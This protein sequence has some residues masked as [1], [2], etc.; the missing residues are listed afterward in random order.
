MMKAFRSKFLSIVCYYLVLFSNLQPLLTEEIS[1]A[2]EKENSD[3]KIVFPIDNTKYYRIFGGES[4]E[5]VDTENSNSVIDIQLPEN[6]AS[7][8]YDYNIL[9]NDGP[10]SY[11]YNINACSSSTP[12][13]TDADAMDDYFELKQDLDPLSPVDAIGDYDCD[14]INN[15]TEYINKTDIYNSDTDNDSLSD[16]EEIVEYQTNP[17]NHDTDNDGLMDADEVG[18][19]L[20]MIA[21]DD[22][23]LGAHSGTTDGQKCP[24]I[25]TNGENYLVIW[26]EEFEHPNYV[27]RG[28]FFTMNGS[29]IGM[30][31][32]V[33]S[34]T[35]LEHMKADITSNGEDYFVVW[36]T[37]INDQYDVRGLI[38]FENGTISDVFEINQ[39]VADNQVSPSVA[40]NGSD[41]FVVWQS[42][43]GVF[44]E[45]SEIVGRI[46]SDTGAPLCDDIHINETT[47]L[48]QSYPDVSSNAMNYLV[49]W[50]SSESGTGEVDIKGQF[51]DNIGNKINSEFLVNNNSINY[52]SINHQE[53]PAVA[54]NGIDYCVTWISSHQDNSSY[55]IS[56]RLIL[57]TTPDMSDEIQVN[58]FTQYNQ[59]C[60]SI[61]TWKSNYLITW[62]SNTQDGDGY[63]VYGQ[64]ISDQGEAIGLEFRINN[65]VIRDQWESE[66]ASA[67]NS[68][69]V[70]WESNEIIPTQYR[71]CGDFYKL[72][73][74]SDPLHPDSDGDGLFDSDEISIGTDPYNSDTDSDG[75]PDGW[76]VNYCFNPL[77]QSDSSFDSDNDGLGNDEEYDSGTNPLVSDTDKDTLGD[78]VEIHIY[79]TNP[80]SQDTDHDGMPDYEEL[81]YVTYSIGSE[82][83]VNAYTSNDQN[84]PSLSSNKD[85]YLISWTSV[86][87]DAS[88][89]GIAGRIID[90]DGHFI[91][92]DN[93]LTQYTN[94]SQLYPKSAS[95]DANYLLVWTGSGTLDGGGIYGRIINTTGNPAGNDFLI[96]TFTANTQGNPDIASNGLNYLVVWHSYNLPGDTST[97]VCARL[98]DEQGTFISDEIKMNT[99]TE[100]NQYYPSVA[101]NKY[102]YLVVWESEQQ[103]SSGF[104]IYGQFINTQ[105]QK[106]G[107]EFKINSSY[108]GNQQASSIA[109][110]GNK[111]LVTWESDSDG[112]G[113]GIYGQLIDNDGNFITQEFRINTYT[114]GDQSNPSIASNGT[115]YL[116]T[117]E[118]QNQDGNGKGIYGQFIDNDGNFIDSEFHINNYISG[119]KKNPAVASR[120]KD[121]VI[122]WGSN[123]QDGNGYGIYGACISFSIALDPT[124]PDTDSDGLPDGWE[125]NN[126]LN[127]FDPNDASLDFDCDGLNTAVEFI[128]NTDYRNPDTDGDGILD[129]IEFQNG[130]DPTDQYSPNSPVLLTVNPL[131]D[132]ISDSQLVAISGQAVKNG[133]L[134]VDISSIEYRID[135]VAEWQ[136]AQIISKQYDTTPAV[137]PL[138][139]LN[140]ITAS[141]NITTVP[142][143]LHSDHIIHLRALDQDNDASETVLY[144]FTIMCTDSDNDGISDSF[145]N[146]HRT[147]PYKIDTDNDGL[148]DGLEMFNYYSDPLKMDTDNDSLQDGDEV[149]TYHTSPILYDTDNDGLSDSEEIIRFSQQIQMNSALSNARFL[150]VASSGENYLIAWTDLW[151]IYGRIISDSG[152]FITQE[153]QINSHT[154]EKQTWPS[155]ASDGNNFCVVWESDKENNGYGIRGQ[156]IS[157]DGVLLN[158]EINI[159]PNS[160]DKELSPYICSNGSNY[161]LT[162][163][164]RLQGKIY[165]LILDN[166]GIPQGSIKLVST[167]YNGLEH[168]PIT[169]DG[170]N[171]LTTWFNMYSIAAQFIDIDGEFVGTNFNVFTD[172]GCNY[173]PSVASDKTNYFITWH[174]LNSS[175]WGQ[176]CDN[177][178]KLLGTRFEVAS[179]A[180]DSF[181]VSNGTTYLFAWDDGI[182]IYAQLYNSNGAKIEDQFI[183]A[184]AGGYPKATA[185][186]DGKDYL[187][188][189][190]NGNYVF[191]KFLRGYG[192]NPLI[193]DCDNDGIKDGDE[194]NNFHTD[195]FNPDYDNDGISDGNEVYEY[196]TN[197]KRADTDND[198]MPDSWEIKYDLTPLTSSDASSDLDNDGLSNLNEFLSG[199]YPNVIDSDNDGLNDNEFNVY[200][201]SPL[202]SDSDNDGMSDGWEVLNSLNPINPNDALLDADNDSIT[203]VQEYQ[204]GINPQQSNVTGSI[205]GEFVVDAS[206]S[207]N[208][209]VP[210]VVPPGTA[211]MD[212][213]LSLNYST[214]A[215]NSVMGIGWS[216]SG[217]SM[218]TRAPA[219]LVQDGFVDGVD[220]DSNDRFALDGQRLFTIN[221]GTYGA[222][223]TEYRTENESFTKVVSYG[224]SGNGPSYFKAW[225]KAGLIMEYGLS[226]DSKIKVNF[227]N[228]PDNDT[229]LMWLVTRIIDTKGN[230]I[231]FNYNKTDEGEFYLTQIDY[232][233]NTNTGLVPYNSIKFEYETRPDIRIAYQSGSKSKSSL[234]LT[235]IKCY[236]ESNIVRSYKFDYKPQLDDT[237]VKYSR[238]IGI[239]QY[240]SD[241]KAL[242]KTVF[243]WKDGDLSFTQKTPYQ[244]TAGWGFGVLQAEL[245]GD[246]KTD[247]LSWGTV[248]DGL[249]LAFVPFL[250]VGDGAFSYNDSWFYNTGDGYRNVTNPDPNST[251][252]PFNLIPIDIN[253]DGLTDFVHMRT[254]DATHKMLLVPHVSNGNCGFVKKN[255]YNTGD[256][257]AYRS[258]NGVEPYDLLQADINADGLMDFVHVMT[259]A[260]SNLVFIMHKSNGDGTFSKLGTYHTNVP[261]TR[262]DI[263]GAS[264]NVFSADI[265]SDGLIDLIHMYPDN[266]SKLVIR[267]YLSDGKG[268]FTQGTVFYTGDTY[269][270]VTQGQGPFNVTP[271]D[272]N[273]DGNMDFIHMLIATNGIMTFVPYLSVGNG[274]FKRVNEFLTNE[275]YNQIPNGHSEF[276]FF[277]A[278]INGDGL[279]DVVHAKRF[280]NSDNKISLTFYT[281]KGDGSFIKQPNFYMDDQYSNHEV[282]P[283]NILQGDINGDGLTDLI[284]LRVNSSYKL[285]FKPYILSGN[286][287]KNIT[288]IK[289]GMEVETTI[290]YKPLTDN[291]VYT[292]ENTS[293]YPKT[294]NPENPVMDIQPP[295]YVVSSYSTSDGLGG[296]YTRSYLYG[297]SKMS[298]KRGMLGFHWM[299]VLDSQTNIQNYSE[300]LQDYPYT[301]MPSK[302][303]VT[304][305]TGNKTLSTSENT[306]ES[307]DYDGGK[308]HFVYSKKSDEKSYELNG[309][310]TTHVTTENVYD[311]YGNAT[312]IIVD[313]NDGHKKTTINNYLN[314]VSKWFLGRLIRAEVTSEAPGQDPKT[315]VSSFAYDT[316]TGLLTYEIVEPQTDI[317][318]V[319]K[320]DYDDYGNKTKVTTGGNSLTPTDPVSSTSFKILP[321]NITVS[322]NEKIQ[323]NLLPNTDSDKYFISGAKWSVEGGGSID[324]ATGVFI[325]GQT[326]GGPFTVTAEYN[327][328]KVKTKLR[329]ISQSNPLITIKTNKAFNS[330]SL[331]SNGSQSALVWDASSNVYAQIFNSS[332]SASTGEISIDPNHSQEYHPVVASL[333]SNF[334]VIWENNGLDGD[335]LGVF[336]TLLS[337]DGN[338]SNTSRIN[339]SWSGTQK[340]PAIASSSDN[341]F[342]AWTN[343]NDNSGYGISARIYN[344]NAGQASSEYNVNNYTTGDQ[345]RPSIASDGSYYLNIWDGS[346]AQGDGIY[347]QLMAKNG[348]FPYGDINFNIF[349]NESNHFST[350]VSIASAKNNSKYLAVWEYGEGSDSTQ[351]LKYNSEI[352]GRI[353]SNTTSFPS[354]SAFKI[355]T[356]TDNYKYQPQVVSE[357]TDFF[358]VWASINAYSSTASV[359]AAYIPSTVTAS[360]ASTAM[361]VFKL[362]EYSVAEWIDD[363]INGGPKIVR[364]GDYYYACWKTKRSTDNNFD[365]VGVKI[366]ASNQGD[367]D[368]DG[369]TNN[370][371]YLLGTNPCLADTDSDGLSD[372]QEVNTY[373]TNPLNPDT[374]FDGY[375]DNTDPDPLDP[376]NPDEQNT[377][378]PPP[379]YEPNTEEARIT[380]SVYDSR[381]RFAIQTTNALGHTQTSVYDPKLGVPISTTGPNGLTTTWE[382]DG[383]G[384]KI[385]ETQADNTST[386]WIN[387]S[388]TG[389]S[390]YPQY[391]SYFA[392]TKSTGS[393]PSV[394]YYDK[395]GRELR[396]Q[397]IGFN[398]N[399]ILKDKQ[400]NNLGQLTQESRNYFDGNTVYWT[401]YQYDLIGRAV[402]VTTPD[403]KFTT[404]AYNGLST[405]IT[406]ALNQTVTHTNNSQGKL[407]KVVDGLG[408][409]TR[410]VYDPLDNLTQS[411]DND[412]NTVTIYYD[413][414]GQKTSMDDP[415]MGHWEY[416][417]NVFGELV[418]QKDA[419]GQITTLE[420]DKLG[421]IVRRGEPDGLSTGEA[422]WEYDNDY[423]AVGKLIRINGVNGFIKELEYDSLGR[424]SEVKTTFDNTTYT[425]G[426]TYDALSRVDKTIY[427]TGF[428]IKNIY[429]NLGFLKQVINPTSNKLYWQAD[430]VD[431]EGKITY[432]TLGNGIMTLSGYDPATGYLQSIYSGRGPSDAVQNLGYSFDALGNLTSRTDKNQNLEELFTYDNLNR[433]VSSNFVG[434]EIKTYQYDAIGNIT[435]KSD[436]GNY[437]YGENGAGPHAVTSTSGVLNNTYTY[438][439]NGNM[440]KNAGKT[441]TYNSFNK[442]ETITKDN[443][444]AN[445]TTTFIYDPDRA[446]YK[447]TAKVNGKDILTYYLGIFEK[448]ITD[449]TIVSNK[450]YISAGTGLVAIY[451]SET[452]LETNATKNDTCFFHKDHLGSID[453]ITNELGQVLERFSYDPHGKRRNTDWTPALNELALKGNITNRGFTGHEHI[454]SMD[455]IHMNGRVYDPILGR[456]LSPD[457]HIESMGNPQTLNRYTYVRNNPLSYTDPSGYFSWKKFWNQI[458]KPLLSLAIAIYLPVFLNLA[459]TY[460]GCFIGGFASGLVSSDGNLKS[461]LISGFTG[462]A[463]HGVAKFANK[464]EANYLDKLADS[465]GLDSAKQL[466]EEVVKK[467]HLIKDIAKTLPHGL[468]GGISNKLQGGKFKDGFL[469]SASAQLFSPFVGDIGG[470]NLSGR[471]E[472]TVISAVIG[473]TTSV[474]GGG[475]FANGAMMGAFKNLYNAETTRDVSKRSQGISISGGSIF[476]ITIDIGFVTDETG[477]TGIYLGGSVGFGVLGGSVCYKDSYSNGEVQTASSVSI[478][479]DLEGGFG[480]YGGAGGGGGTNGGYA[481]RKIG[482]GI[483]AGLQGNLGVNTEI[484]IGN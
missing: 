270:E 399:T 419:K 383:F 448:V 5:E 88:S 86:G 297:G 401:T 300:Y 231:K 6:V 358:V 153:F 31:F 20:S 391:A 166:E 87:Q 9:D 393:V 211:G 349:V 61:T 97:G 145:E 51:F 326:V 224:S 360:T 157:K 206:G 266:N 47:L 278:D 237:K 19:T 292:R 67:P 8:W 372:G 245:N 32:S 291:S 229:V 190:E 48:N 480:A 330:F 392:Y 189:W 135:S 322:V 299:K 384:R 470:S 466:S 120:Q 422:T 321:A 451:T 364:Q 363:G 453:T 482:V 234:R 269:N 170:K 203:N 394:V 405:T 416:K 427:P 295:S 144:A 264:Y 359:W 152:S 316:S 341:Y 217:L 365:I 340:D 311:T 34:Y 109:S 29:M 356:G 125:K 187:I 279:S 346:G 324:P 137:P 426:T 450:H 430:F 433:L 46:F 75:I 308:R 201:S 175:V 379:S 339:D 23:T 134:S 35:A 484:Q 260:N 328:Y 434:R 83:Q 313:S 146:D 116:V 136:K 290:N 148:G 367:I 216:F 230:Y 475:K 57:S 53:N 50:E 212:P 66:V 139:P 302:S 81:A 130:F 89:E 352:Y 72:N 59:M 25:S 114:I 377:T 355:S 188:I 107:S 239:A 286:Y 307:I 227:E 423:M 354:G 171:Y 106:A 406:N 138:I 41:Y 241:G 357:G 177:T 16:Y 315:R 418:W 368:Y 468:V 249:Q 382:Y 228:D 428:E 162:L 27:M 14:G 181:V 17:I 167:T 1:P 252:E 122:V 408:Y 236:A 262:R 385:K 285:A 204:L 56:A 403:N 90:N 461:A 378:E 22:S 205:A 221:N 74:I 336:G 103:D 464:I 463:F 225:T 13:D 30:P 7:G 192:T 462:M 173:Y 310:L 398:G 325:A 58:T 169:S 69:F 95:C 417:Y 268:S 123:Q 178:S 409:V 102:K 396:A 438:D 164:R 388:C 163:E 415:D 432:E 435:Y 127:P 76:E 343:T 235:G 199:T 366:P 84:Y 402:K 331:A 133:I 347:G 473:G 26:S 64:V 65:S 172:D 454:D 226:S 218:V 276:N 474:I 117:W 161:L 168:A 238:L 195:P 353:I 242:P 156:L 305:L 213:D 129:G 210:I 414:R 182:H 40:S 179:D 342:V 200:G 298:L 413:Q 121:Y 375:P 62:S 220:F 277:P 381:G 140:T 143:S 36:S 96:N 395:L 271:M 222:D 459:T 71:I 43:D 92:N 183:L 141:W 147:N 223:G 439:A 472:R 246:G 3:I 287:P 104:G 155:V 320:Y 309:S 411:I 437:T 248:G 332:W 247:L 335:G 101:A 443:D 389:L 407:V 327:G 126:D 33:M 186:S 111:F 184:Q 455:L 445:N 63:G 78:G 265:N 176:Y 281:S 442:P 150:S 333:L 436:V 261:F 49:V 110:D 60:P 380:Q 118:S 457:P 158:P 39:F 82:F 209:K 37:Y 337:S 476:S 465:K 431:A 471:I 420:Y 303:T 85:N 283:L 390:A 348:Y 282:K 425:I 314:D 467:A 280:E 112:N 350:N 251:L 376:N 456:F 481:Y 317:S 191:G 447:Q 452:N 99:F 373:H 113:N 362:A 446:R 185:S 429:N 24:A 371:E 214:N 80:L 10:K 254:D 319:T 197:P 115:N 215:G 18:K 469:G 243:E 387:S 344:Q 52:Q 180:H 253:G 294:Y 259:E 154:T 338:Q 174:D 124:N 370:Q 207:A 73:Y 312:K 301:G 15:R 193:T 151:D 255:T 45:Q 478:G 272:V 334:F 263:L 274:T 194:I 202:N 306:Y 12:Y 4:I 275:T 219:T 232:T 361:T 100:G 132:N 250:S 257:Y 198:G 165:S 444:S 329:V 142:L 397:T 108:L 128:H 105:G 93:I 21:M 77:S 98:I 267:T 449:T 70:V 351:S 289:D 323:L 94:G 149:N 288:K 410:Y 458:G 38:V 44:G 404:T 119:D 2:I 440:T 483:G 28:Q 318:L 233:G 55:G 273:G 479:A 160:S 196:G 42:N 159:N 296:Q 304:L 284:R 91:T 11:F 421:R 54:S 208:Y 441:V 244:T 131:P 400:Y 258:P 345:W 374:D 256:D 79:H 477:K 424:I 412:G 460:L 240:G 293:G 369:L 386:V 68:Y